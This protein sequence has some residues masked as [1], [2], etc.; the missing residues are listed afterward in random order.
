MSNPVVRAVLSAVVATVAAS[1]AVGPDFRP[2]T[3]PSPAAWSSPL[4][5][6]LVAAGVEAEAAWWTRFGDAK[7]DAL[8]ERAVA[9]N[10]DVKQ[11]A[12]RLAAARAMRRGT[13]AAFFPDLNF[14]AD[15]AHRQASAATGSVP[16]F[17]SSRDFD[18]YSVGFDSS[19]E[20]D[21]FG[22][23]RR[24]TEKAGAEMEAADADLADAMVTVLAEVA[25]NYVQMRSMQARVAIAEG[26]AASQLE[27]LDLVRWRFDAGLAGALDVEQAT[28]NR[29]ETRSRVPALE[30]EL[31]ASR[32]RVAVLLGL[33]AGALDA[34]LAAP[35]PLPVVPSQVGVGVPADLLR[36]RP[37]IV[38]AEK[39]LAAATAAVGVATADLYPKLTL[40]GTFAVSA[41]EFTSL[42]AVAARAYSIGPSLRWNL[43]DAG[44]LRS[45]VNMR[46]AEVDAAL[47]AWESAVLA[48]GEEVENALVGCVRE[49]QRRERLEEA[50]AAARRA[51]GL[52]RLQYEN[53]LVDF[54]VVL[55]AQRSVFV[56]EESL[57]DSEAKV[58]TN[59][60]SLYK[61]LGGGWESVR[62]SDGGC[63]TKA[64]EEVTS[65]AGVR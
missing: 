50:R 41:S 55:E 39:R 59:F 28:Y 44:R 20:I 47:A 11:A 62:C 42:D 12:G 58:L 25:R 4:Q 34:E 22:G 37:D 5:G 56:F 45:V 15:Y 6:G 26:N 53:G 1:C 18:D 33:E 23:L 8:I 19:W 46:S 24:A 64:A 3:A 48:A 16:N 21:L 38:A 36:R 31:A 27:T 2:P 32:H 52:A 29:E 51:L 13:L 40:S 14:G 61:A 10:L 57:A 54:Q 7:L 35:A 30:V 60:V 17:T 49:Q 65:A 63:A 9:G 43:F